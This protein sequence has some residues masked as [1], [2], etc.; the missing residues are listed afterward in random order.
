M[1]TSSACWRGFQCTYALVEDRLRLSTLCVGLEQKAEHRAKVGK[2][3]ELGGARP[4][5]ATDRS[6]MGEWFYKDPAI[7]IPYSG[8]F[9]LG[10]EFIREL[11]VHMGFHPAWK[12][13]RVHELLFESG[14]LTKAVDRSEFMSQVRERM[15]EKPLRPENPVDPKEIEQWIQ[16]MFTPDYHW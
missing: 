12:Y 13:R 3:P 2:G 5:R 16:K 8:G 14:R 6:A 15:A 7:E 4:Q 11:Y 9:L 10:A 1:A